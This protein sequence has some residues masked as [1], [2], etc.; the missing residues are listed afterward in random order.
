MYGDDYLIDYLLTTNM[1]PSQVDELGE[2]GAL[3]VQ[4]AHELCI[5]F[6]R[7]QP[8]FLNLERYYIGEPP[9]PRDPERLTEEYRPLLMMGRSDWCQLVVDVVSE[10]LKIGS[11][12]STEHPNQD[13]TAWDWWQ[14]NNMDGV[15]PQVHTA[16]L[17]FGICY[18]SVWPGADGTPKIMGESPL[19]T[20]CRIDPETGEVTAAVRLWT[21]CCDGA[22]YCDLTT[23]TAQWRLVSK[24]PTKTTLRA[25]TWS[26]TSMNL[27]TV[28]PSTIEWTFRDPMDTPPV[29]LNPMGVCGYVP[30][31]TAPDLLGGYHSEIATILP[32]QDRINKTCF[33]RL[34]TQEFCAF[35]Q[36]AISGIDAWRDPE[37]GEV[38]LPFDAAADRIWTATDPATKFT[39]FDAATG[40]AY[41][42]ATTADIQALSTQ[43]RTPPHY[44]LAGMGVFPSGE[45]VRATEYGLTRKVQMRQQSY[46]DAWGTVLR[47]CALAAKDSSLVDD[48]GLRVEWENVEARSEGEVVDALLKMGTLGVPWEALWAKWG[49]SPEEIEAWS[50]KLD[51]T[52]KRA[53]LLA[54]ATASPSAS[55]LQTAAPPTQ[56]TNIARTPNVAYPTPPPTS[57]DVDANPAT[58]V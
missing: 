38:K 8:H 57:G 56:G 25:S 49:A 35:P 14:R 45:S 50:A 55:R 2:A 7:A 48:Q 18:V 52:L 40:Q 30:M 33:D 34:V 39:Q 13:P 46:G 3:A 44:L 32:V 1:A 47:L 54:L 15:S 21:G 41:L 4:V 9:L 22:V 43:S 24:K 58:P 31:Y 19:S 36:R 17:K 20:Y 6:G 23:S 11:V 42:E 29:R 16:A 51:E 28:D 5:D 53:Q 26:M 37:T 27:V 10:R 12:R